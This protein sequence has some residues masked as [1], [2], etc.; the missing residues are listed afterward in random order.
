MSNKNSSTHSGA[1]RL[2]AL[3][4]TVLVASGAVTVIVTLLMQ[5]FAK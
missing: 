5:L 3:I 1:A 4:L 2:L